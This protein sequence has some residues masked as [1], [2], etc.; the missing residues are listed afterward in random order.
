MP[1]DFAR[2]IIEQSE[3]IETIERITFTGG[4]VLL[5]RDEILKLVEYATKL[6]KKTRIVSNGFWARN[7]E[8]GRRLLSNLRRAGLSEL[9]LSADEYHFSELPATLMRNAADLLHEFGYPVIIN[10]V[11][12]H[13]GDSFRD[14]TAKCGFHAS[15]LVVIRPDMDA[16]EAEFAGREKILV[17]N[18]G[19]SIEGRGATCR[20]DAA[21]R[22]LR[23]F[24]G[25][26]MEPTRA[27]SVSPEGLLFPCC[28]P[29][30]HYPSFQ[31]GNLHEEPLRDLIEKL[32]DDPLAGFI[33]TY[34]P[35]ALMRL[36][37]RRDPQFDR[38]YSDVCNMCCTALRRFTGAELREIV[39]EFMTRQMLSTLLGI[40]PTSVAASQ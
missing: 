7:K 20:D 8:S 28:S 29:G 31:V 1:F 15:E 17:R 9:I 18:I 6:C 3:A 10:R 22:P 19:L 35:A 36:L 40:E 32:L 14:F 4:E 34:G 38:D 13:D 21:M 25:P 12:K 39:R 5:L 23:E 27:P 37:A 11:T 24:R 26:C 30:S 33:T 2:R 16:R